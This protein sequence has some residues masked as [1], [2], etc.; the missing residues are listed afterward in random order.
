[1]SGLKEF[2]GIG[3]YRRAP[4]GYMSWQH[5]VFA[6]AFMIAMIALAILVG[7]KEKGKPEREKN[8]VVVVCAIAFVLLKLGDIAFCAL[9]AHDAKLMLLKLPLF[10]CDLQ[11]FALP[12]A[13]FS[14]GRVREAALDFVLIFGTLGAA[15]GV[16]A[17][18]QNFSSYPVLSY[19]NVFS[20]ITHSLG[21]F[22]GLY[23]AI[24]GMASMQKRNIWITFLILVGCCAIAYVADILIPYNY[25][26][27]MRGDGTP[28]DIF[29]NLVKGNR[30]LYP[31]EVVVLFLLYVAAFYLVWFLVRKKCGKKKSA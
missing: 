6:T 18:G 26:F 12:I 9:R 28:Y 11:F 19:D 27:L 5:I 22:A 30:V 4:E 14:K 13:A 8:R 29:Y 21:G 10:M 7:R 31:L 2:F 20:A 24:A 1:M 3:E 25:M 15:M 17:A 16:Y 23:I